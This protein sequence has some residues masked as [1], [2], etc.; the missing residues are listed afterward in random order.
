MQ[1]TRRVFVA[2]SGGLC[3]LWLAETCNSRFPV[4]AEPVGCQAETRRS[5]AN[6]VAAGAS[7]S[8][9]YAE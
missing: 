2:W 8:I 4:A 5:D 3:G 7:E 6:Q 9:G 1:E